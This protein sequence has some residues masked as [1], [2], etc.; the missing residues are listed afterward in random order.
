VITLFYAVLALL[1]L[2]AVYGLVRYARK[3]WRIEVM[4]EKPP[5]SA[6]PAVPAAGGEESISSLLARDSMAGT[7]PAAVDLSDRPSTVNRTVTE[8]DAAP[9][10]PKR[11]RALRRIQKLP[12]LQQ[13][14][15]WAEILGAPKSLRQTEESGPGDPIER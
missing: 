15:V 3:K 14:V 1:L 11:G 12:R 4:P 2:P 6:N 13:A 10:E 9:E 5:L 8:G 7:Y